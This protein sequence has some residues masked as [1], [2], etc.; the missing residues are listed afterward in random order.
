LPVF[1]T[2]TGSGWEFRQSVLRS[3]FPALTQPTSR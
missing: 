2:L 3:K 1:S